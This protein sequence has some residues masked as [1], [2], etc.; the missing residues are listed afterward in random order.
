VALNQP[1]GANWAGNVTYAATR[2]VRPGTVAE[3]QQVVAD[4]ARRGERVHALGARHS[5]TPVADTDGVLIDTTAI[6]EVVGLDEAAATVTIGAGTRYAEL[7]PYL[8][9]RGWALANLPSLPH[10]SVAGAV[11][12]ATHGSGDANP[13]LT[14]AVRAV[15]LVTSA[16]EQR[17]LERG[18]PDAAAAIVG[19]GAFGV[20]THVTLG[21]VPRFEVAQDVYV[22]VAFDVGLERLDELLASAYSVSLFTDWSTGTFHQVWRKRRMTDA[23]AAD[24]VAGLV[25]AR[26]PVHPIRG[27]PP[28]ACTTQLG[29][30]G[31][32]HERLV[33]FRADA[34]PSAGDE[35]QSEYLVARSD[36]AEALRAVGPLAAAL[37]PLVLVSEVRSVAADDLWLSPAYG[38][39]SVGIHFTWRRDVPAVTAMLPAVEAALAPFDPRPHWGKLSAM[40]RADAFARLA[41]WM[42]VRDRFDPAG[43]FANRFVDALRA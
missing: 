18:E 4:A 5:F 11:A 31:P 32:W 7:A 16:G 35:L 34:T 39:S 21:L 33:H 37:A 27:W 36:A 1:A 13:V 17:R 3:V 25:P 2:V 26:R 14:D 9:E 24:A 28:D 8:D 12:T 41:D 23:V 20:L 6:A 30:P 38:R 10:V 42:A 40:R 19:L 29:R 43:T 15:E 22:D